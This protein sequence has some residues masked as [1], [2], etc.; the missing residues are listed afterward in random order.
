[1]LQSY[2]GS[3]LSSTRAKTL[4]QDELVQLKK[5]YRGVS[6]KKSTTGDNVPFPVIVTIIIDRPEE[7]R[8]VDVE[9]L[10]IEVVVQESRSFGVYGT[11]GVRNTNLPSLLKESIV[12]RISDHLKRIPDS[13]ALGLLELI[14]HVETEFLDLITCHPEFVERYEGVDDKGASIRRI[15]IIRNDTDIEIDASVG[16]SSPVGEEVLALVEQEFQYLESRYQSGRVQFKDCR[17]DNLTSDTYEKELITWLHS[18]RIATGFATRSSAICQ[19]CCSL[20][21][22]SKEWKLFNVP[23]GI[24]ILISKEYP[25][26]KA[27]L[28]RVQIDWE[29][30]PSDPN[31]LKRKYAIGEGL[32]RI[33][34]KICILEAFNPLLDRSCNVSVRKIVKYIENYADV[35]LQRSF[36]LL[37][38]VTKV[39]DQRKNNGLCHQVAQVETPKHLRYDNKDDLQGSKWVLALQHLQLEGIDAMSLLSCS[40][41]VCCGRCNTRL[42]SGELPASVKQSPNPRELICSKCHAKSAC[43]VHPRVVHEHSNILGIVSCSNCHPVDILPCS[44]EIQCNRCSNNGA[45]K[46]SCHCGRWNDRLC[47]ECHNR[48]AFFFEHSSFRELPSTGRSPKEPGQ[49]AD[50]QVQLPALGSTDYLT[51][52]DAKL[53]TG[54]PLPDQGTCKHYRHSHR[55]LRFPCCGRRFPCDLCHEEQTDGHE[56]QWAKRMV[57]GFCSVEQ[58]VENRCTSC[59][60]RVTTTASRPEGKNTR[61][62]EGGTGQRDRKKLSRKDPHKYK[63][64]NKKTQSR[65]SFRVGAQPE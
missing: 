9:A 60:K 47:R 50:M 36:S 28:P 21:P 24:H 29:N 25:N 30:G 46:D 65:K 37:E 56:L 19:L 33:F 59:G 42:V 14:S 62:W 12:K 55:W 8:N 54:V 53:K 7:F 32:E 18:K 10:E 27:L 20:V 34:E 2:D 48:T 16:N 6:L 51:R 39:A 17:R 63:N 15:A 40:L 13:D 1:M 52:P 61:Y 45:M 5:R 41:E 43:S 49:K 4:L 64:S 38:E 26:V 23:V 11:V 44:V 3:C 58:S 57:C 35:C 22:S 31:H